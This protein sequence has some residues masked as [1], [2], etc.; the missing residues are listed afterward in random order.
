MVL[1]ASFLA[2]VNQAIQS[3]K[4]YVVVRR[5]DIILKV[6]VLLTES[7]YFSALT[8]FPNHLRIVF[9]YSNGVPPF[10]KLVLVSK[11]SKLVYD[12][13]RSKRAGV[14]LVSN[15]DSTFVLRRHHDFVGGKILFK[16]I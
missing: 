10:R 16:I 14:F 11:S 13:A 7:G 4:S 5:T 1:L 15:S 9:R 12:G 6:V 8:I 3:K 2:T